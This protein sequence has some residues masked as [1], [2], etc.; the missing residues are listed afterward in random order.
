V[1]GGVCGWNFDID[2]FKTLK[3]ITFPGGNGRDTTLYFPEPR[4]V[5][6]WREVELFHAA[7]QGSP[8]QASSGPPLPPGTVPDVIALP[9][10]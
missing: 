6:L 5:E 3:Q 10:P 4:P 2:G 7:Q 1:G 8:V 9:S